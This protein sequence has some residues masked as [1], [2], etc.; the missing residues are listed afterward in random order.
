MAKNKDKEKS[1]LMSVTATG[2]ARTSRNEPAKTSAKGGKEEKLSL[3]E[4]IS[5]YFRDLKSEFRKVTWPSKKEVIDNTIVVLVTVVLLG[6][7]V[8]GLDLGMYKLLE[9]FLNKA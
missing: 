9:L 8:G 5:R 3:K 6:L 4:K 7:F 2:P 1:E